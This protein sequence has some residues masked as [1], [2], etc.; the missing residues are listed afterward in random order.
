MIDAGGWHSLALRADGSIVAWG[1]NSYGQCNVPSE[2]DFIAVS[3]GYFC[4][5]ALRANGSIVA[6]GDI[7][8]IPTGNTFT[9]IDAGSSHY[10]ALSTVP[11]PATLLLLG[12]GAL[13]NLKKIPRT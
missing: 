3:A 10:L 11:E 13:W 4:S 2:N 5:L 7:T 6:W 9:D 12:L 8:G 1:D